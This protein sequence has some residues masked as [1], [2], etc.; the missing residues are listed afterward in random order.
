[1]HGSLE[2]GLALVLFFPAFCIIGALYCAFPRRPRPRLRW[3]WDV[4][5]VAL[6]A[7]ASVGAMVWGFHTATG[8]GSAIWR[9]LLATLLVY[10]A[11][12]VVIAIALPL[13]AAWFK[14]GARS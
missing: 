14:R 11:F 8:I 3:L 4:L 9:Q 5:V 2:I 13:R 7:G 10:A 1:M 12:A 6:A